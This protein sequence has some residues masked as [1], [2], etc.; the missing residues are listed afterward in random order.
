MKKIISIIVLGA[1]SSASFAY[2]SCS[3]DFYGNL[4]C[5][6][7]D[8]STSTTTRDFY[9]NDNT[10]FSDGSSLSCSTDFYGNYNCY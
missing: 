4:N 10:Y 8:G 7:D 1:L 6:Y 2:S 3:E 5:Y 9:G